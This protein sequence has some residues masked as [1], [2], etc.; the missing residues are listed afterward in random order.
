MRIL[1]ARVLFAAAPAVSQD[2]ALILRAFEQSPAGQAMGVGPQGVR[3]RSPQGD[4]VVVGWDRVLAVPASLREAAEPFRNLATD[5]WRA[6]TRLERGDLVLAEPLLQATFERAQAEQ[7]LLRGPTG[8][9][10]AEGL[11]RC[12]LARG[13][14][15]AA[16]EPWLLWMDAA[17]VRQPRTTFANS[18]WATDVGLA[19]A[20]D[21]ASELCPY[22]PPIWLDSP[23]LR[24][25]LQL[26][27]EMTMP[28]Q[29]RDEGV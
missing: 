16:I 9:V 3:V 22:L 19:S 1:A 12:R 7:R 11:L 5:T 13:A 10:V 20:I 2:D 28:M 17:I 14:V 18:T 8:M 23:S 4:V 25:V 21:P 29:P 24:L 15:A 6:R 26:L 27:H